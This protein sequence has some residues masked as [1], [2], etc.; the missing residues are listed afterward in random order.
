MENPAYTSLAHMFH[1][2]VKRLGTLP[3][4]KTKKDGAYRALSYAE[5]GEIV[6]HLALGLASLGAKKDD[7]IS[8]IS[9]TREEWAMSDL[10]ILTLG[11]VTVPV[12]PTLPAKQAEYILQNSDTQFIFISD[13]EQLDKVLSVVGRCPNLKKLITFGEE[14]KSH[15]AIMHFRE[16]QEEGK[17]FG[18]AH[19]QHIAQSLAAIQLSDL[20]TLIYTSGTTG[21]PKGVMLSHNNILSNVL[22]ASK[23]LPLQPGETFLSFLPLSHVFERTAGHFLP[24]CFGS[25]VA[26]AESID[27]VAANMGEVRPTLMTAVPR[28]YEKMYGRVKDGIAAAPALRKKIFHWAV[29]VGE[30]A[31]KTGEKGFKY[32]VANKLVFS[33]LHG[34]LGGRVKCMV[35]GGAPLPA[36]IAEFFANMGVRILEG[37]GLTETSPIITVNRPELVKFG[38]VGCVIEHVEVKIAADGEILTRGPNVMLGYYK[39]EAAT[40]EMIDDDGWLHTGDIG[41]LDADQ[42]LTIT[43]RKKNLIVTSGGKNIA[44]Q[45]IENLLSTNPYIEQIMVIGDKRNYIAALIVPNLEKIRALGAELGVG[46]MPDDELIKHPKIVAKVDGLIQQAQEEAGLARYEKVK[47]FAMLPRAFTIETGELTPKL[48]IKRNVVIDNFAQIINA[49]YTEADRLDD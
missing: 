22:A 29:G 48:S 31:R 44:P 1:E 46:S 7:K 5:V 4:Y 43:D 28:L 19:P 18:Q 23:V 8:I 14:A 15:P 10:A 24:I 16:L 39:N 26:Y 3:L 37:Y 33:K 11:A 9:S 27:T 47:K 49:L 34:R 25:T 13:K 21:P 2:Q 40:K 45:P 20:A 32:A 42:Y 38:S 12:Y 17:R 35:S 36:E 30:R 6:T 41:F